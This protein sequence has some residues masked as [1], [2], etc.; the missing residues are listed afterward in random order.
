MSSVTYMLNCWLIY[1]SVWSKL[2]DT[3]N[4][5]TFLCNNLEKSERS[6]LTS[7]LTLEQ[8]KFN[9]LNPTGRWRLDLGH[10]QQR[11]VMIQIIAI[12]NFESEFSKNHSRRADTSQ[13]VSFLSC[14]CTNIIISVCVRATG[15]I[16]EM[17]S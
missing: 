1:F 9:W 8:F 14:Y 17:R 13:K 10:R 15:T 2:L 6:D 11:S 5:Y 16:L 12:N 4:K 3:E 7:L